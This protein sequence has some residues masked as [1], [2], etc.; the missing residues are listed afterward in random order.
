MFNALLR[1]EY[2]YPEPAKIT[3]MRYSSYGRT[4]AGI[5]CA[6]I[7]VLSTPFCF[8]KLRALLNSSALL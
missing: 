2:Q 7:G 1:Y 6:R 5:Y 8:R 3:E 4:A